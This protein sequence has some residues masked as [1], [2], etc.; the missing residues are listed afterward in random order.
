MSSI[1]FEN[2]DYE[3]R[4][5]LIDA[6]QEAWAKIAAPGTWLDSEQRLAVVAEIRQAR[7]CDFCHEIKDA[8]SPNAVT[9]VHTATGALSDA[10]VEL[11]HRGVSDPGRLSQKWTQDVLAGGLS[12]GEYVE[13]VGIIASV[14]I[15]DTATTAL[16]CPDTDAPEVVT[17]EPSRYQPPGA[18]VEAAWLPIVEPED[19]VE[20]DG[21]MYPSP[22]AGYIYRGLSS[23]PE[24][25]RNYWAMANEH[26]LP[27][28]Y[29]YQFDQTIRAIS[30]PQ[31]ELMAARGSGLH[32][33]AY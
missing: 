3:V 22:K 13:I 2:C 33:C 31:M 8:L 32:Q 20:A 5:N 1:P 25:M 16:G 7:S 21:P 14:M 30:R 6:H 18:R 19:A 28:Q 17:G 23:V 15:M 10:E 24:S 12:E 29:V 4:Q 26:Y 27:G 9:G 11:I